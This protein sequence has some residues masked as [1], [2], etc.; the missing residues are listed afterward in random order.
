LAQR[1]SD[2]NGGLWWSLRIGDAPCR[3]DG[4]REV[5]EGHG[6]GEERL[7]GRCTEE[8]EES[9]GVGQIPMVDGA[10]VLGRA[11][12]MSAREGGVQL[13]GLGKAACSSGCSGMDERK[14]RRAVVPAK[15]RWLTGPRC[16]GELRECRLG[17]AACSSGG[18]G[19]DERR[20]GKTGM[21]RCRRLF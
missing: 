3:S 15:S 11:T 10:P 7:R 6:L 4:E 12:G 21:G 8:R 13:W 1:C 9:G 16:S 19:V 2:D 14:G 20:R 5:S 18:S 17:K